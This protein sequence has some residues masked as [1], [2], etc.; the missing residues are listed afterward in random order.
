MSAVGACAA[1][2]R[3]ME[4][5]TTDVEP[6]LP[7]ASISSALT[8][9]APRSGEH[10]VVLEQARPIRGAQGELI[11]RKLH[12]R[13]TATVLQG[14]QRLRQL[15]EQAAPGQELLTAQI[16]AEALSIE[17]VARALDWQAAAP[18]EQ[19]HLLEHASWQ[20]LSNVM[21]AA[22]WL[23]SDA[24]R[25]ICESKLCAALRLSMVK[26]APRQPSSLC[27]R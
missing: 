4:A 3:H 21:H 25:S 5:T 15:L 18:D 8:P 22:A 9:R 11:A 6:I 19:L 2:P 10:D 27:A 13:V 16:Q 12:V 20:S 14:S 17:A 1:A 26:P 7:F 23:G 24:L